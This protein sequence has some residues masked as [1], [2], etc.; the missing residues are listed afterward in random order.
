MAGKHAVLAHDVAEHA[1][2]ATICCVVRSSTAC[3]CRCMMKRVATRV[4][5]M[6]LASEVVPQ[7]PPSLEG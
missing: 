2:L 3:A 4:E 7:L 1:V 5:A 6:E